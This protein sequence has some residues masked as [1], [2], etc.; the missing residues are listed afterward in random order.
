M[1]YPAPDL[2]ERARLKSYTWHAL[3][4]LL[5]YF[6]F[7]LPGLVANVMFLQEARRMEEIAGEPLPGVGMLRTMLGSVILLGGVVVAFVLLAAC[8]AGIGS[9]ISSDPKPFLVALIISGLG[10]GAYLAWRAEQ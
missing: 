4:V 1:I 5:L 2:A 3:A 10:V 8:G 7:F 9:L 6:C